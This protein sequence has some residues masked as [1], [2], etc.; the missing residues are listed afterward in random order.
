MKVAVFCAR[1]YDFEFLTSENAAATTIKNITDF[2][3]GRPSGNE[4]AGHA[5]CAGYMRAALAVTR[6]G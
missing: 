3:Q 6:N 2:E 1:S 4:I 5:T